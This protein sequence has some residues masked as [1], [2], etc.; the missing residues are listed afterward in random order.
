MKRRIEH[1]RRIDMLCTLTRRKGIVK[2]VYDS[3]IEEYPNQ[4]FEEV[5]D[6]LR[7]QG[8]KIIHENHNSEMI[9][10]KVLLEK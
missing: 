3:R 4:T 1:M 6:R 9:I 8:W 2:V 10:M 5:V 7:N